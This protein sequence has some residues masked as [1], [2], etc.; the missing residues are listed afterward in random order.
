[1]LSP[2]LNPYLLTTNILPAN[3]VDPDQA[4]HDMASDQSLQ[5]LHRFPDKNG[6]NCTFAWDFSSY[7]T[8]FSE[9]SR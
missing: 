2:S 4:P 6:L 7:L 1:M 8:H 9:I 3:I 5:C